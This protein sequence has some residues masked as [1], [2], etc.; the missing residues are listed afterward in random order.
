MDY[1]NF[2]SLLWHDNFVLLGKN[3]MTFVTQVYVL[4]CVA[5][6]V[7]LYLLLFTHSVRLLSLVRQIHCCKPQVPRCPKVKNQQA[8]KYN[9]INISEQGSTTTMSWLMHPWN[10]WPEIDWEL[11]KPCFQVIH[12]KLYFNLIFLS[13][14]KKCQLLGFFNS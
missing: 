8:Q 10:V 1:H 14:I 11:L 7:F 3:N 2:F 4:A 5:G 9:F 13:R 12:L 6:N